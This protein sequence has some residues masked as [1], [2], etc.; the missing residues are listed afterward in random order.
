[1]LLY[2]VTNLVNEKQ[3]VGI[4]LDLARRRREHISGHGSRIVYQAIQKYG[5]ENIHFEPWYEG[6]EEWIKT[7]EYRTILALNTFAPSGYNLTFGGEGT[8]GWKPSKA[9]REKMSEAHK[10]R[11]YGPHSDE[12]RRKISEARAGK[13]VPSRQR[14][15][16]PLAQPVTVNGVEFECLRDAAEDLGVTEA[17]LWRV[18]QGIR[19]NEFSYQPQIKVVTINGVTYDNVTEAAKRLGVSKSVLW[20]AKQRAGSS[21]FD[22]RKGHPQRGNHPMARKVVVNGVKYGCMKDAAEA[23]KVNYSAIRD[24]RRHAGSNVFTYCPRA[25]HPSPN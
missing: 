8:L 22:F 17:T 20:S 10:G 7:M 15:K 25:V 24:A 14:G 21:I 13:P 2:V 11:T 6:D 9:I 5:V 4:T 12:T 3:Y 16:H 18:R 19:S 23:L 1:M